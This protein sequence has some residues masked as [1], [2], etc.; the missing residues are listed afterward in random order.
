MKLSGRNVLVSGA[1]LLLLLAVILFEIA[2]FISGPMRKQESK[3]AAITDVIRERYKYINTF[4]R[5]SFRYVV[6]VGEAANSY[7]FFDANGD[8]LMHKTKRELRFEEVK[9]IPQQDYQIADAKITL[10]YGYENAVYVIHGKG[11]QE[12]YLDL[13]TLEEVGRLEAEV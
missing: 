10:G 2:I 5:H 12:I 1:L 9:A 6:Y 11:S 7:Y 3:E 8:L 4:E 13:D